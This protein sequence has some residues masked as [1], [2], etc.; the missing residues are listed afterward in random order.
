M[1]AYRLGGLIISNSP[2]IRAELWR[3]DAQTFGFGSTRRLESWRSLAG[4]PKVIE[5]RELVML[6]MRIEGE[7]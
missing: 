3:L 6:G 4:A 7:G 1:K 2:K 5:D